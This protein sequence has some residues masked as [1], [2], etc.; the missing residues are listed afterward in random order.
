[1]EQRI[2]EIRNIDLLQ[3]IMKHFGK[4]ATGFLKQEFE[5]KDDNCSWL[6]LL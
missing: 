6:G 5:V 4:D 1:M 2:P 3:N